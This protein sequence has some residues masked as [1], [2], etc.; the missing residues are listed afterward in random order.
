[1]HIALWVVQVL[2][3]FAFFMAGG[4][5]VAQPIEEL[6]KQMAFVSEMPALVVR[7]IGLSEVL[8]AIGLIGLIVP[9]AT[10]IKPELTKVAAGLLAVVMLLAFLSHFVLTSDPSHAPPSLVLGLLSAFVAWGRHKKAP[11][12]PRGA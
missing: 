5:K 12:M 2:L 7:F 8:G 11:I 1:M 9:A 4:T 3:A 6:A 10:R